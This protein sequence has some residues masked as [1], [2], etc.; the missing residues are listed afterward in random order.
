MIWDDPWI[1]AALE[2]AGAHL[3]PIPADLPTG[4]R[5]HCWPDGSGDGLDLAD[6]ADFVRTG[7]GP[8][9][10]TGRLRGCWVATLYERGHLRATCV[11]RWRGGNTWLLETLTARPRAAGWGRLLMR[12][13]VRWL[14]DWTGGCFVLGFWWELNLRTAVVAWWRGWLQAAKRV[15]RGWLYVV[16]QPAEGGACDFCEITQRRHPWL[17]RRAPP[18]QPVLLRGAGWSVVASDSGLGDGWCYISHWE[19]PADWQSVAKHGDWVAL[20]ARGWEAP[21]GPGWS[22]TGELVILA[23]LATAGATAGAAATAGAEGELWG[24]PAEIAGSNR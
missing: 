4:V 18:A 16:P 19:G 5:F 2:P 9:A 7:W 23:A 11:L 21:S 24:S 20:W 12:A 15:E 8:A 3:P 13:A 1:S 22:W 17:P 6:W 10:L 14:W